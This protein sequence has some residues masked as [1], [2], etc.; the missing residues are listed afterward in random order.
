[1][2]ITSAALKRVLHPKTFVV[3][4]Q[5]G[6]IAQGIYFSQHLFAKYFAGNRKQIPCAIPPRYGMTKGLDFR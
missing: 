3:I 1:M 4:P 2:D 5:R 6:G